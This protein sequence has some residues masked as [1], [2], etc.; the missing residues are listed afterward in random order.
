MELNAG[1]LDARGRVLQEGDEILLRSAHDVYF[2]VM[3]ITASLDPRAPGDLL[4]VHIGVMIPFAAQRGKVNPEFI[5]VR[6]AQE[7]GPMNI[8]ILEA[9]PAPAETEGSER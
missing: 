5:R 3:S 2:R 9:K 7:A 4:M 1:T 6:T 8:E